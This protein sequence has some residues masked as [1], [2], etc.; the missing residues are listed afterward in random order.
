MFRWLKRQFD[1]GH[2][3]DELA[4]RL[5]LPKH[6]ILTTPLDYHEFSIKKKS[7]KLRRISA[8]NPDL[9]FLQRRLLR[10]LLQRL[11]THGLATGFQKG[12]SFVDNAKCHQSQA[13]IIRIDLIDFFTSTSEDVVHQYFRQIGWNRKAAELLTKLTTINGGLPQGAPT[14]PKLS[15]LVNFWFDFRLAELAEQHSAIYTRYADDITFSLSE[16]VAV[17]ALV[18]K[19]LS[20]IRKAGYRPHLKKKFDI[21]RRHQRQIVT[22]LVVNERVNLS[23]EKRRWLRAVEH[24]MDLANAGG[25]FGPDPTLT[26]EQ[27]AGWK[28]LRK[29]I[30]Q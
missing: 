20:L 13:V 7:G 22:G 8:P 29:M 21:R 17:H 16:D 6:A 2:D 3:V 14:S 12:V 15:N 26:E 5:D 25:Y 18:G 27:F 10:R 23:R 4:R 30:D 9:K 19:L 11:K 1:P 24:R 28:S